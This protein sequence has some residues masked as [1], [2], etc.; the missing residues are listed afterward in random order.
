MARRIRGTILTVAALL[1]G[2]THTRQMADVSFQPP[3]GRYRLIVM[4]PDVAVG[5]LTT[6]GTVELR[7]DW[8]ARARANILQA[9]TAQQAG[10]GGTVTIAATREQTGAD[11]TQV[12]DLDRLHDVVGGAI[13]LHKYTAARLPTKAHS[14]D[15]TLGEA[16]VRF[17][18]TTGYDYAL[19]LHV[20]DSFASTGR[21]A[22]QA[23][24]V[25]GCV[26]GFCIIPHGG[27]Q[28]AFASLVDLRTGR[29][30]WFNTLESSKG[31]IRETDG[32]DAL[33]AVLLDR[34]KPGKLVAHDPAAA[35]PIAPVSPPVSPSAPR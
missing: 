13:R 17:G 21:V 10:R 27:Q 28:A 34:M 22:V 5:S 3:E 4:R 31:D 32:A 23:V 14:F 1:G 25:I 24:A 8:T 18:R 30:V 7:E 9:I 29:I 6:G 16:A 2:C 35:I 11:S 12:A 33:I 26:V 15:W 19:F 20:E